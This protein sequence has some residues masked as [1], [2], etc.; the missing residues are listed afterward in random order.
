MRESLAYGLGAVVFG[1]ATFIVVSAFP[2][3]DLMASYVVFEF[4]GL[5]IGRPLMWVGIV[6]TAMYG[7]AAVGFYTDE[8]EAAA[9]QTETA[10]AEWSGPSEPN[11]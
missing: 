4:T 11:P 7:L 1:V 9:E 2:M 6:L 3:L 10:E 5:D 8:K